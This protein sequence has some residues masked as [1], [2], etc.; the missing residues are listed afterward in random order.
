M[1]TMLKLI[2]PILFFLSA[3]FPGI[4]EV[5]DS[6]SISLT[7]A[8]YYSMTD[9]CEFLDN[10]SDKNIVE[11]GEN[12]AYVKNILLVF[13]DKNT[14]LLQRYNAFRSVDSF[15]IGYLEPADLFVLYAEF[16]GLDAMMAF[17]ETLMQKDG[18]LYASGSY[19]FKNEETHTP[20]DPFD[21]LN[22][23]RDRWDE[24]DPRGSTWWL[25]SIEARNAW[26]YQPYFNP[27]H[28]GIIDSGF[29]TDHP[30]LTGK[31]IFPSRL[32][33]KQN[34]PRAHGTHVAGIIGALGDNHIG[35]SG[36]V[37]NSTLVCVD[38]QTEKGQLW[39]EDLRIIFGVGYAIKSGAKVINLSL[40]SSGSIPQGKSSYPKIA[41]DTEA[42]LISFYMATFLNKGYDFVIVQS[43][44]NGDSDSNPVDAINNGSFCTITQ[45]NSI[46]ALI[47]VPAKEII[48]RIIIVGSANNLGSGNFIQSN[49]SNVGD[50][51]SICAPGSNVF[52]CSTPEKD[53]YQYMSGTSMS[54]PVVTGVSSLVWSVNP[55][56]TGKQVKAIVCDAAHTRYTVPETNNKFWTNVPYRS[57]NM[58]NAKL[59]VEAAVKT[60]YQTGTVDGRAVDS[61]AQGKACE[62]KALC[63]ELEFRFSCSS[64]GSFNFILP[65]GE[66]VLTFIGEDNSHA[67]TVINVTKDEPNSLGDIILM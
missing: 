26:A 35:I 55:N 9:S 54:A 2:M 66:A 43:A 27:I 19:A 24:S 58:V 3:V 65:T 41:M 67:Q 39:V 22:E 33:S 45:S 8:P 40:G 57:Y 51:V 46:S 6:I 16:D 31:I 11:L 36:I 38:W 30:D 47:G 56:L 52:S 29:Q 49:F 5:V 63:G 53:D 23:G 7:G 50:Q 64:D 28:I 61:L 12:T 62:I 42:A 25:E 44:G 18:V 60:L 10:L 1:A 59:A 21:R 34:Y 37:Q 15:C 17:T 13:M 4:P 20:N 14:S 48:D 32:L